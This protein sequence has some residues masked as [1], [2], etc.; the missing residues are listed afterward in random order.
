MNKK[1]IVI[2]SVLVGLLILGFLTTRFLSFG[3]KE[4]VEIIPTPT[5]ALPTISEDTSVNLMPL[6]GNKAVKLQIKGITSDIDT[7][8]YELT[9]MASGGLMRGVLGKITLKGEK[10]ITRDD[11]VLGTCSSGRCVY[12]IGVTSVDL[13]L[14]FNS[15]TGEAKVFRKTYS[16]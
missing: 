9:Y 3:K 11:I 13:A 15:N 16:L 6:S 4:P 1:V 12:D 5:T 14:K 10:E 2:I 8:E 7:I